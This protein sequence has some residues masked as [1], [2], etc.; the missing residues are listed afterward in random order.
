MWIF[1][2]KID[3]TLI[4]LPMIGIPIFFILFP[5]INN[6]TL[7]FF[8]ITVQIFDVGH[9]YTTIWMTIF[10]RKELNSNKIMYLYTPIF[11]S[12]IFFL[13]I[14][15]KIPYFWS[16]IAYFTIYHNIKQG[17]GIQRWYQKVNQRFCKNSNN[18]FYILTVFPVLIAHFREDLTISFYTEK[19]DMLFR[20][21]GL[22]FYFLNIQF[23]N[24]LFF[25]LLVFYFITLFYFFINEFLIYKKI[26]K[27]E[28]SRFLYMISFIFMYGISFIYFDHIIK[29]ASAIIISHAL[30]Y[31]Y[32]LYKKLPKLYPNRFNSKKKL[33]LYLILTILISSSLNYYI[34][35][36]LIDVSYN[37]LYNID[38]IQILFIIIYVIPTICHFIWDS[39]IWKSTHRF[40]NKI[41]K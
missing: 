5:S 16:F 23:D 28:L 17:Y 35:E 39:H 41:Y 27:F 15:F 19:Q 3:L 36:N 32:I 10:D 13:W 24:I 4:L 25:T 6:F 20:Y 30:I 34:Q 37:Y 12:F 22:D 38:I 7:I 18:F 40:S 31:I 11:I 33:V 29:I 1:N 26:K 8:L 21:S 2:K 9:V 14:Y